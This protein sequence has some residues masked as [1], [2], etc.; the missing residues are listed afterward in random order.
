MVGRYRYPRT[1]VIAILMFVLCVTIS[2]KPDNRFF[3]GGGDWEDNTL[4]M[5]LN[6]VGLEGANDIFKTEELQIEPRSLSTIAAEVSVEHEKIE[7]SNELSTAET[8]ESSLVNE[9]EDSKGS[10]S[11]E[12]KKEE[13]DQGP[14]LIHRVQRGETLWDIARSYG[15]T[16]ESII[17]ANNIVNQN[18]IQVGQELKILSVKGVLHEVAVGESLW[19]I[20]ERYGV[21]LEE[22]VKV[23]EITNPSTIQPKTQIV[24]PG[25]T[26][27]KLRDALVVNGQLQRAFSW[28]LQGRISS[29]F[30]PRWGR[31]HKGLDIA[32]P[33]GTQVKAAADGKVKFSGWNGSYGNLVIID[34]GNGVETRYAHLDRLVAQVGQKVSRGQ[35]VAYSGNTGVSTGPHLHFEIR[36]NGEAYD[37]QKY[38]R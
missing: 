27:L 26:Q 33:I 36:L 1:L 20:S 12:N 10:G 5:A 25:A 19:E 6:E 3:I 38:L 17:S 4:Q 18:R 15:V 31:M 7:D 11:G 30:G 23:N 24:I 35:V 2:S 9:A 8:T 29:P 13:K 34:H 16:I 14:I 32:V 22:I 21:S 28:P 37:P